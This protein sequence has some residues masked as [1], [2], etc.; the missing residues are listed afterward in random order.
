LPR[1]FHSSSSDH[2]NNIWCGVRSIKLL[3]M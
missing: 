3:V 1:P 2:P